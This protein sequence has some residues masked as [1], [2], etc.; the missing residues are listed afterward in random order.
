[1]TYPIV[2]ESEHPPI[3]LNLAFRNVVGKGRV[4]SERYKTWLAA[5]GWDFNGKGTCSGPF[6]VDITINTANRR[7]GSDL[8]NRAKVCLDALVAYGIVDDDSLC[9]ELHMRWGVCKKALR[10]EVWPARAA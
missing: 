1:M 5:A 8:D 9:Q 6:M 3:S 10:I 4:K 7:K 2:I